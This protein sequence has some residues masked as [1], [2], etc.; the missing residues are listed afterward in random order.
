[1]LYLGRKQ[2]QEIRELPVSDQLAYVERTMR[3]QS[4][5]LGMEVCEVHRDDHLALG[6]PQS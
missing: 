3:G 4:S 6:L 5:F 1:M 2:M